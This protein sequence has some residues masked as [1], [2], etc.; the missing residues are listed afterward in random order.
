MSRTYISVASRL[1]NT[2]GHALFVMASHSVAL[3]A[4]P[5]SLA[6]PNEYQR[7]NR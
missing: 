6:L 4:V 3:P 5:E 2:N 1:A 7:R